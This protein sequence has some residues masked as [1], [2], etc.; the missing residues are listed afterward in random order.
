[1]KY[2]IEKE[3]Y[4][5]ETLKINN[6]YVHSKYNP[7]KEAERIVEKGYKPHHVHVLFGWGL[8]YV[9]EQYKKMKKFDEEIYI[10]DPLVDLGLLEIKEDANYLKLDEKSLNKLF[11]F[12]TYEREQ[13]GKLIQIITT[14]NYDKICSEEYK[15]LLQ[16]IRNFQETLLIN[17]NTKY[18][19]ALQWEFNR[20]INMGN[21]L[22]SCSVKDL[23]G[24]YNAPV[25]VASAGPSLIK[26]L[27]LVRKYRKQIILVASGSTITTLMKEN[28]E[29]D[30]ILSLDGNIV[31][32][33][34][35]KPLK[36][37]HAKL[38]YHMT[39]HPFIPKQFKAPYYVTERD[40]GSINYRYLKNKLNITVPMLAAGPSVAN[41]SLSFALYI[42][43]GKIA[44]IGQD[45]AFTN[46]LSHAEGN[47]GSIKIKDEEHVLKGHYKVKGY[48]N[49]DVWTS[50]VMNAMKQNF[51]SQL[52]NFFGKERVF[53]CTEGGAYIE[54]MKQQPFKEFCDLN[55]SKGI[56]E[57][58]E[59]TREQIISFD[60]EAELLK[61]VRVQQKVISYC[62]EGLSALALNKSPVAFSTQTLKKL[63]KAEEQIQK[64]LSELPI[65]AILDPI[66]QKII[67]GYLPIVNETDKEAFDRVYEQN[68]SLYMELIDILTY[69]NRLYKEAIKYYKEQENL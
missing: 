65:K 19:G 44:F 45:L 23:E 49:D 35:F 3:Q 40:G 10:I 22:K 13:N 16:H 8:G 5:Y 21:L 33:E 61:E 66:Q 43:T 12:L 46:N 51:E 47:A 25:V 62:K 54:G 69:V 59:P 58:I 1:M 64:S 60:L 63:E 57:I 32:Y 36:F 34:L 39:S 14:P 41:L 4:T 28:I 30:Y 37:K 42:T 7:I 29:P 9:Y 67:T 68:K 52:Q 11:L 50:S 56:V 17:E 53:N 2:T 15:N 6:L 26:Q 48:Y 24:K 31:N 18:D 55:V 20:L 27:P 38:I